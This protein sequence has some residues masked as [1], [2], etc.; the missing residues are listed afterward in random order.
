MVKKISIT[1]LLMLLFFSSNSAHAVKLKK[2]EGLACEAIL[3]AV[4]IAIPESHSECRKVLTEWSLYLATLG[5]FRSSP[6]CPKKDS[7]NNIIGYTE[8][9]CK[10]IQD[11]EMK[12]MCLEATGTGTGDSCADLSDPKERIDCECRSNPRG[13]KPQDRVQCR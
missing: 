13:T 11:P 12:K 2:G 5:P 1:A 10:T 9:D 3:C 8:M 6:K 4:G 7:A